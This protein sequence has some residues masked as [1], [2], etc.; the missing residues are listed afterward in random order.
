MEITE[1]T[2][3]KTRGLSRVFSSILLLLSKSLLFTQTGEESKWQQGSQFI[4]RGYS[5]RICNFAYLYLHF[6]QH[7]MTWEEELRRDRKLLQEVV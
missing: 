2:K 5:L 4:S 1:A 7:K 3:R 6:P